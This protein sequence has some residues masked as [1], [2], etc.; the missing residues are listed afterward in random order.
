MHFNDKDAELLKNIIVHRRDVRGNQ[1]LPDPVSDEILNKL[2]FAFEHSPSVGYSQPWQIIIIRENGIK[3]NIKEIFESE[4]Q[5]ASIKF[6]GE[7][8]ERYR[9]L[10]L[11]GIV[12][13]PVNIAVF[14][15]PSEKPVLGQ[16]SMK[17]VGIYSVICGIQNMWLMA[18]SLNIGMG[19]VSI[20]DEEKVKQTLQV[21][22]ELLLI[23]YLCIGY[24]KEFGDMPELEILGWE[25]KKRRT[26]FIHHEVFNGRKHG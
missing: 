23:G 3:Q 10:K 9:Q 22:Q 8:F 1:F 20:L 12:E 18:R 15:T 4:N 13:A 17:D 6:A 16:T 2:L 11:E 14:Y 26:D 25:S 7:R 24:V 21:P 5:S 19:W